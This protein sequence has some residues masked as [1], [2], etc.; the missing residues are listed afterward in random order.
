[1]RLLPTDGYGP[2]DVTEAIIELE[3]R[4]ACFVSECRKKLTSARQ[5][6]ER[7]AWSKPQEISF[8]FRTKSKG[9]ACHSR[10]I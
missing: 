10:E 9:T 7:H 1:M 8:V 2:I 6:V 5:G 4:R 3:N